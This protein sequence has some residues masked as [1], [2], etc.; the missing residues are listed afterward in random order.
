MYDT[1][2][3]FWGAATNLMTYSKENQPT[4]TASATSKKYSS[5]EN[6]SHLSLF[7][8]HYQRWILIIDISI[9]ILSHQL[10][11]RV[12]F[13]FVSFQNEHIANVLFAFEVWAPLLLSFSFSSKNQ[14]HRR[15]NYAKF[16][17]SQMKPTFMVGNSLQV[18]VTNCNLLQDI[19]SLIS[20]FCT[21][22]LD[23]PPSF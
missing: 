15:K 20:N 7:L 5:S 14:V 22:Y 23:H 2:W 21:V 3:T 11:V 17:V 9:D 8:T 16:N 6:I 13:M 19:I 4:K 1:H 10:Q 18:I 12:K